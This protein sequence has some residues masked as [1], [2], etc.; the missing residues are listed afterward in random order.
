MFTMPL[1]SSLDCDDDDDDQISGGFYSHDF[2]SVDQLNLDMDTSYQHTTTD[3]F[4]NTKNLTSNHILAPSGE[5]GE[6][7][8]QHAQEQFDAGEKLKFRDGT[9]AKQHYSLAAL[10]FQRAAEAIDDRTVS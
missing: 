7:F 9:K 1:Q 8:V 5:S 6:S 3:Q 10:Y 2:E 4:I